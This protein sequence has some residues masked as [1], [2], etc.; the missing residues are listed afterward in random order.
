MYLHLTTTDIGS[1]TNSSCH[2]QHR[3]R[4]C[5][6]SQVVLSHIADQATQLAASAPTNDG[7]VDGGA[8]TISSVYYLLLIAH[9]HNKAPL[10]SNRHPTFYLNR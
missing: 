10:L 7:A 1:L 5:C 3:Q 8:I 2:L 6:L 9:V 4:N